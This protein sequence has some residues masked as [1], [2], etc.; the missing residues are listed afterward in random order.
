MIL[1]TQKRS[2]IPK[3]SIFRHSLKLGPETQD[4]GFKILRTE[5]L[6]PASLKPVI[7]YYSTVFKSTD[8]DRC[9]CRSNMKNVKSG[10]NWTL[11]IDH[12]L[13]GLW[14]NKVYFMKPTQ[15]DLLRKLCF[16][17]LHLFFL[18]FFTA[19]SAVCYNGRRKPTSL[20]IH[21]SSPRLI[22]RK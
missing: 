5:P 2:Y 3:N 20:Q 11:T 19:I 6:T 7:R 22:Y 8:V 14:V 1:N 12:S 17:F 13:T 10:C 18:F 4:R 21:F 16:S 9:F 15:K